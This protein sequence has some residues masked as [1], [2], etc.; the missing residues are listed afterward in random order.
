MKKVTIDV[1]IHK[2]DPDLTS[3]RG[4]LQTM[5]VIPA[6]AVS[7]ADDPVWLWNQP[8]GWNSVGLFASVRLSVP[9][10]NMQI[11]IGDIQGNFQFFLAPTIPIWR[12]LFPQTA[13]VWEQYLWI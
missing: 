11:R 2:L 1:L 3:L 6:M 9:I 8:A 13:I 10:S 12:I 5:R 4:D 7:L